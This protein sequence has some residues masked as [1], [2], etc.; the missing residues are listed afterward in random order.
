MKTRFNHREQLY[1]KLELGAGCVL[2]VASSSGTVRRDV[3]LLDPAP[4]ESEDEASYLEESE[5]KG[6]VKKPDFESDG[7][8]K[9]VS[10]KSLPHTTQQNF[11]LSRI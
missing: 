3:F 6:A 9:V 1:M 10:Q 4:R 5:Q 8:G 11:N 2:L 7:R